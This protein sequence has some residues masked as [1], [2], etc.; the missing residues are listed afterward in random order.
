MLLFIIVWSAPASAYQYTFSVGTGF[1]YTGYSITSLETNG[2]SKISS[3][4]NI[5]LD[6]TGV[7]ELEQNRELV[8]NTRI[9][10]IYYDDSPFY[11]IV[12]DKHFLLNFDVG[13]RSPLSKKINLTTSL[14]YSENQFFKEN[15]TT[16]ETASIG[17]VGLKANIS[18]NFYSFNGAKLYS[19]LSIGFISP[20]EKEGVETEN[21]SVYGFSLSV[22]KKEWPLIYVDYMVRKQNT[23]RFKENAQQLN[24]GLKYE[25]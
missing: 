13:L 8:F 15:A 9:Q 20:N 11:T 7:L 4:S 5:F 16:F 23:K 18:Y 21:G 14:T 12:E 22:L 1:N 10:Q 6:V 2:T 25:F 19:D 3:P 17:S 24:I